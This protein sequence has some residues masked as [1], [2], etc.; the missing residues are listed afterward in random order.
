L[1]DVAPE[2]VCAWF[3]QIVALP[4]ATAVGVFEIESVLDDVGLL[5]A[6]FAV[7]V[8]VTLPA[9]MSAALGE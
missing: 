3:W 7:N 9:A 4:P 1:A 2:T 6:P 8:N 5:Q